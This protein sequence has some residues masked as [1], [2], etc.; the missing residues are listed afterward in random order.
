[1]CETQTSA[2]HRPHHPYL[3]AKIKLE[4]ADVFLSDVGAL[5]PFGLHRSIKDGRDL[6]QL[7]HCIPVCLVELLRIEFYMCLCGLF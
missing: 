6:Q 3:G 7:L 5:H 4:F 1:M 2:S